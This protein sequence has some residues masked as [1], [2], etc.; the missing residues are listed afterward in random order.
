M[1]RGLVDHQQPVQTDLLGQVLVG[2]ER[3]QVGFGV[4]VEPPKR[5]TALL[6][7]PGKLTAPP[8]EVTRG[9]PLADAP[10]DPG[11]PLGHDRTEQAHVDRVQRAAVP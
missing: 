3:I 6:G 1:L 5:K 7:D 11:L 9:V 8:P 2:G 10:G 4:A